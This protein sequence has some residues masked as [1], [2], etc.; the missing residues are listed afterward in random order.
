M[1]NV[2]RRGI[3]GKAKKIKVFAMD[4]DGVLTDGKINFSERGFESKAWNVKDRI[5]FYILRRLGYK[6]CWIS[7]RSGKEVCRRARDL[8]INEVFL[9]VKDKTVLWSSLLEKFR[10]K[11]SEVLYIGDDLVDIGILKRASIAVAPADAAEEV[12]K[13]C[14]FVTSARGG[15]GVFRE[16]AEKIL[17]AQNRWKEVLRHYG[18]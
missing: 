2:K 8:K 1:E 16:V 4:V 17:K 12:K 11:P 18:F 10:V 9:G 7:G 6:T 5:A 14:D 13:V 15:D 3:A